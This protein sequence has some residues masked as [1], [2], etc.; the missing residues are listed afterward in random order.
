MP[1]KQDT[2]AKSADAEFTVKKDEFNLYAPDDFL[3]VDHLCKGLLFRFYEQLQREGLSPEEATVL[4]S[5]AD[6]FIR[7]F[8]VDHKMF[9]IFDEMPGIVRQF[10]GNWFIIN[11]VE[12]DIAQLARHLHGIRAF[13]RFLHNHRMISAAYLWNVEKECDDLSYYERRIASFLDI[14][15][16]GYFA[17]EKECSL[18]ESD[19]KPGHA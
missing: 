18:Q 9:N 3:R 2:G 15:G 12:P 7:D 4:A 10:A 17:W 11:S 16:D 19:D 13:Y 1:E 6:Y 5:G 14:E 8:V